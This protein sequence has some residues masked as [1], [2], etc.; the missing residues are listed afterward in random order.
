MDQ[1][2]SPDI[3]LALIRVTEKTALCAGRW[4]GSGNRE[5]AHREVTQ[6]MFEALKGVDIDG[7]IVVGE[8]GRLKEH[9]PLDTG[10]RVGNG[11]GPEVDIVVD[12]I[13]GTGFVVK[14]HPGAIS[15]VAIAPR[16][17]MWAPKPAVYLEKI[18][19]DHQAA[20]VLVPECMG[21]PVAW[22]L[23]LIAR[24]KKKAI[25]DLQVIVLERD[26]HQDL[27][28]EIRAAGARV[29]LRTDGDSAGA[30]IAATPNTGADVLIGVGGLPEGVT[31]ACAV[32][33]LRGGMLARLA[34]QSEQ[35]RAA[36]LHAGLDIAHVLTS[37]QLVSSNQVFFAATGV[38]DGPLLAGVE[39]A[40]NRAKTHSLLIRSETGI[41]RLIHA[42]HWLD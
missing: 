37:D 1:I 14:G 29:L 13:D 11:R 22:S 26:R 30:L 27:I 3:G 28:E 32:K 42:E 16:G 7:Y 6:T 18:I 10:Q 9:S 23:A 34:P 41:R 4:L 39:F 15:V 33:A 24:A 21:A 25:R 20:D 38:T 31:A 5:G 19:V 2:V 36:V 35:E 12:P 40:G 17:A 8:E